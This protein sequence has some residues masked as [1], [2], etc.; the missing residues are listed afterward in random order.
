MTAEEL[1]TTYHIL[2]AKSQ[3]LYLQQQEAWD[4][5][6]KKHAE[7][8]ADPKARLGEDMPLREKYNSLFDETTKASEAFE[9]FKRL[10]WGCVREEGK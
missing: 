10:E 2:E 6:E 4:A 7:I 9:A 8:M 1:M 3:E 5:Y